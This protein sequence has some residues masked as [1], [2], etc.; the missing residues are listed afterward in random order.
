MGREVDGDDMGNK[1]STSKWEKER[2][3]LIGEKQQVPAALVGFLLISSATNFN[4]IYI[5]LV[6]N[7]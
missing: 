4:C 2:K 3:E 6:L 1:N 5:K 7:Q